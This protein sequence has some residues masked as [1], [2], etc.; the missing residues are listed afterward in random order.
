MPATIYKDNT[1]TLIHTDS[2]TYILTGM[3]AMY[4]NVPEEE[5]EKEEEEEEEEEKEEEEK[6]EEKEEK[7]EEKEGRRRRRPIAPT[8]PT[9]PWYIG[10]FIPQFIHPV[11]V[12]W[13]FDDILRVEILTEIRQGTRLAVLDTRQEC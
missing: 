4:W 1:Y 2:A 8:F 10:I 13:L 12:G 3:S 5:E 7:E 9:L 11:T 6:E